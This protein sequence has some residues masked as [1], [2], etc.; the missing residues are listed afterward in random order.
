MKEALKAKASER[1]QAL[2]TL[3]SVIKNVEIAKRDTLTEADV[4]KALQS[5]LKKRNE[6]AIAFQSGGREELAK[7]EQQE[8]A[9]IETYLPKKM[10]EADLDAAI[11]TKAQALGVTG[12]Q[13]FGKLM[14][15]VMKEVGVASDGQTVKAR[16]EHFLSS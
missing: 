9:L 16:V 7:K 3:R 13:D 4:L 11:A 6:A 8:A 2:R 10:S 14:G 1:L 5:E 15:A 12:K